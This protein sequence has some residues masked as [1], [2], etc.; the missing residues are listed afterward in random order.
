MLL[1]GIIG[2]GV[3]PCVAVGR[4]VGTGVFGATDGSTDSEATG[5]GIGLFTPPRSCVIC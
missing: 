3:G 4:T 1:V 5:G 2:D